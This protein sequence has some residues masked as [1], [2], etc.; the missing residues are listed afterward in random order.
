MS[1]GD[2][3]SEPVDEDAIEKTDLY[4]DFARSVGV[5]GGM[6][7]VGRVILIDAICR[8]SKT[9]MKMLSLSW[10]IRVDRQRHVLSH[11]R[12]WKSP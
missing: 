3:D 5:R 11:K 10:K 2:E 8:L 6:A 4:K 12:Q 1:F 9:R 7:S